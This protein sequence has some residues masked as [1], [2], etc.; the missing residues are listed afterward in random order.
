MSFSFPVVMIVINLMMGVSTAV[1]SL[2]SRSIG[3]SQLGNAQ[4]SR[5]QGLQFTF[6]TCLLISS[7]GA[8][9]IKPLFHLLGVNEQLMHH[10]QDYMLIWYGGTIF[11]SMTT[12]GASI[13]RAKGN[14][15]YPSFVFILGSVINALLDP[16]LIFGWGPIP[17]FGIQGAAWT[18]L[19][20]NAISAYLIFSKLYREEGISFSSMFT[21]FESSLYKKI[22]LISL[23]T[24]LAN[25]FVPLSTAFTN[26]MLVSY[27][28][29][30]VA[31]NS[32]ATRIE[33][34]PFIAIFAL[35]SV[36]APFIGQNWGAKKMDRVQ[37]GLKKSFLFS[38]FLGACCSF[39]LIYYKKSITTLFDSSPQVVE[40]SSLYFSFIPLTYGILGAVFLTAHAMN[41]IGKPFLGNLL[42]ASRLVCIYIPLAYVMNLFFEINGIFLARFAANTI[43][44]IL[45]I[46]L[47]Y[48]TFFKKVSLPIDQN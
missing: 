18:T 27:G 42:S 26:W 48:Q 40:I 8:L 32:I 19:L 4:K 1:N 45:S 43:V 30:A 12:V 15:S 47:V 24:A 5:I 23:P 25:S 29:A 46:A 38:L 35:G 22:A 41:A 6:L 9:T 39:V 21:S 34:V 37:E 28:N 16:I 31:A 14:V 20:G 2:V 13:F 44:G 11:M 17:A 3:E 33:T 7:L 10:V 36:L